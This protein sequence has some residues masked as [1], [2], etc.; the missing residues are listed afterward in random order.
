[1]PPCTMAESARSPPKWTSRIRGDALPDARQ[2][3]ESETRSMWFAGDP[4]KCGTP[5]SRAWQHTLSNCDQAQREVL[6]CLHS[7]AGQPGHLPMQASEP[8]ANAKAP[9]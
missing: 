2:I 1:M 5:R 7:A 4:V 8:L 6:C 3:R 9:V